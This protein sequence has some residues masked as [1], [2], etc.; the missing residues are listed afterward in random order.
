MLFLKNFR[1]SVE[2]SKPASNQSMLVASSSE[3]SP[4]NTMTASIPST[5]ASVQV[6]KPKRVRR[7]AK[8]IHKCTHT[9][10]NKAYSKSSHLKAH[11]RTHS[12]EKPFVC[13]WK[14]CNWRFAR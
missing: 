6:E 3:L 5:P 4:E 9:G 2:Y 12:G 8:G 1:F 14:E 11:V 10:C 7:F 13:D